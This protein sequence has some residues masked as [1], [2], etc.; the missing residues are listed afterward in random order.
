MRSLREEVEFLRHGG[1]SEGNFP[2]WAITCMSAAS[3]ESV[4]AATDW[5]KTLNK[6][7]TFTGHNAAGLGQAITRFHKNA[8][9]LTPKVEDAISRL[10]IGSGPVLRIAHTPDWLPYRSVALLP[11]LLNSIAE[12]AMEAGRPE[13]IE[14]F[15]VVDTDLAADK[16]IR[17]AS[18]PDAFSKS[19]QLD[20][21]NGISRKSGS[22]PIVHV[23]LPEHSH[24]DRV[25]SDLEQHVRKHLRSLGFGRNSQALDFIITNLDTIREDLR[26]AHR[27]STS[28]GEMNAAWLSRL[29]N[30]HWKLP[31]LFLA[32]TAASPYLLQAYAQVAASRPMIKNA[33]G[34]LAEL[35]PRIAASK[36]FATAVSG[37]ASGFWIICEVCGARSNADMSAPGLACCECGT[38]GRSICISLQSSHPAEAQAR[39]VPRVLSDSLLDSYFWNI[40]AGTSYVGSTEH[41]LITLAVAR[42]LN[43]G[44]PID[45]LWAA[46]GAAAGAPEI[47]RSRKGADHM[48]TNRALFDAVIKKAEAGRLSIVYDLLYQ[49]YTPT[50][51]MWTHYLRTAGLNGSVDAEP[52]WLEV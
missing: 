42:L 52:V 13:S 1:Q 39:V 34:R 45:V 41:V 18:I 38:C 32:H 23:G 50:L 30:N 24:I 6:G 43:W 7:V 48:V 44:T 22:R 15:L 8:G 4:V 21:L 40:A 2:Q 33:L 25:I 27:S 37:Q 51:D 31:T 10:M 26:A 19:G 47:V 46:N 9:T 11:V 29:V 16:R 36:Y 3:L 28:V 49:G 5:S 12:K 35:E 17:R 20:L 14:I